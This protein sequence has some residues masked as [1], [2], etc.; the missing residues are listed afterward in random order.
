MSVS[1]GQKLTG[2]NNKIKNKKKEGEKKFYK[3]DFICM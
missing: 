3:D 2:N 1:E